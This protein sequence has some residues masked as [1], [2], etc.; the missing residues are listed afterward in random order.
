M[1]KCTLWLVSF[2]VFVAIANSHNSFGQSIEEDTIFVNKKAVI[3]IQFPSPLINFRT[4][5]NNAPYS[6]ASI[7]PSDLII[8][9]KSENTKPALLLIKEGNNVHQFVLAY[10][11]NINLI[12]EELFFDYSTKAKLEMRV[13]ELA[14]NKI[15]RTN[16][17]TDNGSKYT[18]TNTVDNEEVVKYNMILQEGEKNLKL[19]RYDLAKLNFERALELMPG[20]KLPVQRLVE[21]NTKLN[22][23][24]AEA[25]R[26]K[27][28]DQYTGDGVAL[29][30]LKKYAES[31]DA[32]LKALEMR[33]GDLYVINQIEKINKIL[34]NRKSIQDD[35]KT[36]DLLS[37]PPVSEKVLDKSQSSE[38]PVAAEPTS[39]V[40]QDDAKA[41]VEIKSVNNIG[42][43]EKE[44]RDMEDKYL[45]VIET[46]NKL[47]GQRDYSKA[48]I[49]YNKGLLIFKRP[50]PGE[51]IARIDKIL[52]D[53]SKNEVL[54]KQQL[55]KQVEMSKREKEILELENRYAPII[56]EA[57]QLYESGDYAKAK[58]VYSYATNI[59][60][61]P[62]PNEQLERIKLK[63]AE[64]PRETLNEKQ[65]LENQLET[66]RKEREKQELENSYNTV[67]QSADAHFQAGNYKDA[68]ADYIRAKSIIKRPWPDEQIA[69][70][71]LKIAEQS[72]EAL[73]EQQRLARQ[74]ETER[75]ER[76]K[77][78]LDNKYNTV[79]QSADAHFHAGNY[80]DAQADYIRAKSIIKRP[81]PDEQ[82]AKIKLKIAEQ[83]KEAFNEK[84]RLARQAETE[85]KE[86]EKQE[87]ENRYNTVI[88]SADA[89][90]QAGNY[91]EA[92][93]DYIRAK[94]IIKKPWPDE[95]IS[96]VNKVLGE[97]AAAERAEKIRL[98]KEA[99]IAAQFSSLIQ[100]A[101]IEFDK[102]NY[103]KAR[104]FYTE[105]A[106][107]KPGESHPLERL[108]AIQ[109][110]LDSTANVSKERAGSIGA[111]RELKKKYDLA[112][113]TG[114]SFYLKGDFENAKIAYEEA[115]AL[116][117]AEA[118]SKNQ[119]EKINN[120]IIEIEKEKAFNAG[121]EAMVT[122][123]DSLLVLKEYE[124]ALAVFK[125]ANKVKPG[126]TYPI[127]Q[128]KYIQK[129]I[130]NK[131]HND[132][133]AEEKAKLARYNAA[134]KKADLALTEK[135]F[136]DAISAY[137]EALTNNPASE[138]G[139]MGLKIATYQYDK[140][141]EE[142]DQE[143]LRLKMSINQPVKPVKK[144][145]KRDKTIVVQKKEINPY[146]LAELK[147]KYPD[148][149][150]ASFP[151]KQAFNKE[152]ANMVEIQE[153]VAKLLLDK[154][155]LDLSVIEQSV[156]MVCQGVF[157]AK[158][159][160]ILKFLIQNNSEKD[161]L[162]GT[163]QLSLAPAGGTNLKIDPFFIYPTFLPVIKP[164]EEAIIEYVCKWYELAE[165][166][167]LEFELNDRLEKV[168]LKLNIPGRVYNSQVKK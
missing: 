165:E 119:L 147:A 109:N 117:P 155:V 167:N 48:K 164:G 135:R 73:N 6:L 79:I 62:W 162:T 168:K 80:Q 8:S 1:K 160:V 65:G 11:K 115:V 78:E 25:E 142:Y 104:Q 83:S 131:P 94:S 4:V 89:H 100:K 93:A 22:N 144:K 56:R 97:N 98:E 140:Q 129:E 49:E 99:K 136:V 75:K 5:P 28:Y 163:M 23:P 2:F 67:I 158:K 161:F 95:Q 153:S 151:A 120:R 90:F 68:Q 12:E 16:A 31:K 149:N 85:R 154:P 21:I 35:T 156:K 47:Y 29:F 116:K 114:K 59:I 71:K 13:N 15:Y 139:K 44:T 32:Y 133:I 63:E 58:V 118:Y 20:E 121:Y 84:Q 113:S 111:S 127:K 14:I 37:T 96:K 17:T 145:S 38:V 166:D 101:G 124:N 52:N 26:N 152:A 19:G 143:Q 51:Q 72:K 103:I 123:A 69:K 112:L 125:E 30:N 122:A 108:Q 126:E 77:Q 107:L 148:I 110:V 87:L 9:A 39:G 55:A 130:I 3:T 82:I 10:K 157:A 41:A 60:N 146:T 42:T 159:N 91:K 24:L 88:Q 132:S 54:E 36:T 74:A 86:R 150:F 53:Q 46:A 43:R 137:N 102:N 50:W 18:V 64:Q 7:P 33:K 134:V 138:T 105:A 70:I 27:K 92:R 81:W 76:E 66:G 57:D 40:K 45:E 34:N 141:K 128:L 106:A 61:K